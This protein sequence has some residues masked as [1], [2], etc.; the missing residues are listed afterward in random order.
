MVDKSR[1]VTQKCVIL[2]ISLTQPGGEEQGKRP[3]TS[4]LYRP[5]DSYEDLSIVTNSLQVGKIMI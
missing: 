4:R 3:S 5:S 2:K 1:N